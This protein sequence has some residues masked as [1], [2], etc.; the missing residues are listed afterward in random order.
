MA[1]VKRFLKLFRILFII[2]L[3]ALNLVFNYQFERKI[4]AAEDGAPAAANSQPIVFSRT[5]IP[6][7]S[8][9]TISPLLR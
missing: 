6:S 2:V 9:R 4:C 3:T 5:P 8:Q 7:I 1:I